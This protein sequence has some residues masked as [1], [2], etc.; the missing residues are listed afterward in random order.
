MRYSTIHHDI[1][2]EFNLSLYEYVVCD[3]VFQLSRKHPCTKSN[4]EI[5]EF[6]GIDHKTVGKSLKALVEKGLI[7][8]VSDGFET[9]LT[10]D[11]KVLWKKGFPQSGEI[12]P[13]Y[14][15]GGEGVPKNGEGVPTYNYNKYKDISAN[16]EP[17]TI[18]QENED[19]TPRSKGTPT[20]R[21]YEDM[22]KWAEKQRGFPFVV[23]SKQYAALKRAKLA[24]LKAAE[25]KERWEEMEGMEFWQNNG[26]DWTNVV[27]S[28]DKRRTV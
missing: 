10:W 5:G 6:L 20:P 12:S 26:F 4:R 3:S 1:R 15:Q 14:E 24:G 25:L 2:E 28:F 13:L 27:A 23:R 8:R 19:G 7:V 17:Y 16:A 21:G 18:V 9:S 22:C 11:E